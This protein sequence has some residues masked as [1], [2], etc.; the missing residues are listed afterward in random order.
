MS[1]LKK[2]QFMSPKSAKETHRMSAF[3]TPAIRWTLIPITINRSSTTS[4][5]RFIFRTQTCPYA[6]NNGALVVMRHSATP[7]RIFEL[8]IGFVAT[9]AVQFWGW[10]ERSEEFSKR[11]KRAWRGWAGRGM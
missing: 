3:M 9:N 10:G 8:K 5:K 2:N 4:P 1:V 6:I 7:I 11:G